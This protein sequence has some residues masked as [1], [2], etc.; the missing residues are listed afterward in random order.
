[1]C[2]SHVTN[3]FL[4][5]AVSMETRDALGWVLMGIAL[6]NIVTNLVIIGSE[7]VMQIIRNRRIKKRA[8]Q[9]D[10]INKKKLANRAYLIK[11]VPNQFD[12][13]EHEANVFEAV[14]YCKEWIPERRWLQDNGVDCSEYEQEVKF[15][16]FNRRYKLIERAKA[17]RMTRAINDK[18]EEVGGTELQKEMLE[19]AKKK[20]EN[21]LIRARSQF[22]SS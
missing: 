20:H 11:N 16:E 6:L 3:V 5:I 10:E 15:V 14:T 13:F 18:I 12:N 2:C 21:R 4:N 22:E 17:V 7:T 9:I 1:M 8:K 19:A